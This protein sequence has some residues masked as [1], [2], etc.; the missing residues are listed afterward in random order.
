MRL[1]I[2]E[3]NFR[4]RERAI[5]QFIETNAMR[6]QQFAARIIPHYESATQIWDRVAFAILSA[7]TPFNVAVRTLQ[8]AR[9]TRGHVSASLVQFG[10]YPAKI[11]ALN[12]LPVGC[13]IFALLRDSR[14]PWSEYRMRLS[15]TVRGL[16]LCKASFT[17]GLLYP[18]TADVACLDT[19][20]QQH[21]LGAQIF[22]QLPRSLYEAIEQKVRDI[23][24]AHG[25]KAFLA[26][27]L[28]W[29]HARGTVTD[30]NIF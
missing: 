27:W 22:R 28:I 14:E 10:M 7:H 29:D 16:G 18:T 30:H 4:E 17:A 6:Y 21:Y 26:Q 15:D 19:H 20:M 23:G 24:A 3:Q 9:K 25:I 13:E 12:A 1:T 8:H 2:F 5:H 11:A